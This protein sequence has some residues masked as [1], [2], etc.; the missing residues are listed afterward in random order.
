[1]TRIAFILL[2]FIT[3]LLPVGAKTYDTLHEAVEAGDKAAVS[4]MCRSGSDID[5]LDER[6]MTPLA[7]AADANDLEIARVLLDHGADAT[8]VNQNG[9]TA[10]DEAVIDSHD[11][12][13]DLILSYPHVTDKIIRITDTVKVKDKKVPVTVYYNVEYEELGEGALETAT[14]FMPLIAEYLDLGFYNDRLNIVLYK[15][16]KG[17]GV[18]SQ[19]IG[20]T[21]IVNTN[22]LKYYSQALLYHELTHYWGPVYMTDW[23]TEGMVSM[24]ALAIADSSVKNSDRIPA[25]DIAK[26]WKLFNHDFTRDEL[27]AKDFRFDGGKGSLTLYYSKSLKFLYYIYRELGPKKFKK[28]ARD[29]CG[30]YEP[31][32]INT[33]V[34]FYEGL[35]KGQDEGLNSIVAALSNYKKMNWMKALKGWVTPGEY[36]GISMDSFKDIDKDGIA[37]IDE[38]YLG[39]DQEKSD[40]D[41]DGFIDGLELEY[42]LDPAKPESPATL[43]KLAL[44]H[45]PFLDGSGWEWEYYDSIVVEDPEGDSKGGGHTDLLSY[46]YKIR[47]GYIY[48]MAKTAA[49]LKKQKGIFFDIIVDSDGNIKYDGDYAFNLDTPNNPWQYRNK[50]KKSY[51]PKGLESRMGEVIEIKIPLDHFASTFNVSAMFKERKEWKTLDKAGGWHTISKK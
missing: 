2:V 4:R 10:I 5:L 9:L 1:M 12:M 45:G 21:I 16:I 43:E 3:G 48:F 41:G 6:N 42:G 27:L 13:V 28:M 31:A 39:L 47:D 17:S 33:N 19:T 15:K 23:F 18:I 24:L 26:Y 7:R 20:D 29:L 8:I 44:E 50:T 22:N 32:V 51:H 14:G 36:G 30:S 35:D 49:P 11:G 25:G 34:V 38:Y 46:T 40:T 37:G